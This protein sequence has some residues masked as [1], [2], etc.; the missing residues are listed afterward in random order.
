MSFDF[1]TA[2]VEA[3]TRNLLTDQTM[4]NPDGSTWTQPSPVSGLGRQVYAAHSTEILE[5]VMEA[6]D[7]DRLAEKIAEHMLDLLASHQRS[8]STWQSVGDKFQTDLR[9][10]IIDIIA[11]QEGDRVRERL[12]VNVEV[13]E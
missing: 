13:G 11:K 8:Y 6:V 3:I 1:E 4:M 5:K 10:R 7:L 2:I 12:T 9:E